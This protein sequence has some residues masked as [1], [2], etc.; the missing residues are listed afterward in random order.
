MCIFHHSRRPRK[1]QNSYKL[2]ARAACIWELT[3]TQF[4]QLYHGGGQ[5]VVQ[6]IVKGDETWGATPCTYKYASKYGVEMLVTHADLQTLK[7]W[8]MRCARGSAH[9][10]KLSL[11]MA[12]GNL[13]SEVNGVWRSYGIPSKNYSAF[14]ALCVWWN[15][16]LRPSWFT[17]TN[18]RESESYFYV[19]YSWLYVLGIRE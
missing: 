18:S 14:I 13:S 7:T 2:C 6:R 4:F 3:G 5:T 1:A 10:L 9:H 11:Q 16:K 15:E 8:Q 19:H 12:S 17:L